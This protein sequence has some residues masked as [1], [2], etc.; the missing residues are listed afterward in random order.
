MSTNRITRQNTD[1]NGLTDIVNGLGAID[2][3]GGIGV[4][5]A[6]PQ[7]DEECAKNR[8]VER[9]GGGVKKRR[10]ATPNGVAIIRAMGYDYAPYQVFLG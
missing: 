6:T 3:D 2:K 7:A 9:F 5:G 8:P 10:S 4:S 1:R